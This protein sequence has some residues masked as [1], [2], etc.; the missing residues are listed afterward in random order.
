[1]LCVW[2][3]WR[4]FVRK[5]WNF[6]SFARNFSEI[7][8]FLH[9]WYRYVSICFASVQVVVFCENVS[10][11]KWFSH[12][13]CDVLL[14]LLREVIAIAE[15]VRRRACA[16]MPHLRVEV[17]EQVCQIPDWFCQ[18]YMLSLKIK[19]CMSSSSLR[20]TA[21]GSLEQMSFIRNVLLDNCGNSGANTCE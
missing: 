2:M 10:E 13:V 21:N 8:Q 9:K 19:P 5:R 16:L 14:L 12:G 7:S 6:S 3:V 20:E 17:I 11:M 15:R 4:A 18:R 1:M